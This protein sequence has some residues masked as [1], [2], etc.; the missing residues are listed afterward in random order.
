[1]FFLPH[2]DTS[3][4]LI[5]SLEYLIHF[6]DFLLPCNIPTQTVKPLTVNKH[7][8][9]SP[10][11]DKDISYKTARSKQSHSYNELILIAAKVISFRV[12]TENKSGNKP[13]PTEHKSPHKSYALKLLLINFPPY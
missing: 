9:S 7:L 8:V 5:V 4:L 3:G 1:M 13:P 2:N 12:Q 6:D 11:D 10:R